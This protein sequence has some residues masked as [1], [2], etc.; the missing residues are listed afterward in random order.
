MDFLRMLKDIKI[1][2]FKKSPF[3][4]RSQDWEQTTKWQYFPHSKVRCLTIWALLAKKVSRHS[5][6][7]LALPQGHKRVHIIESK[8]EFFFFF[9]ERKRCWRAVVFPLP[10]R[11]EKRLQPFRGSRVRQV[12]VLGELDLCPW[13]MEN[14][15]TG[16]RSTSAK[17]QRWMT[18]ASEP[19]WLWW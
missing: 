3:Q 4:L 8:S 19:L 15:E 16:A 1:E 9:R 5:L 6:M 14:T 2:L 11:K 12:E 13:S 10:H 18:V 17:S 7:S